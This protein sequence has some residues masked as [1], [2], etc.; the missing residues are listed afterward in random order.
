MQ[1]KTSNPYQGIERG[2]PGTIGWRIHYFEE[3][4]STQDRASQLA[5]QGAAQGTVVIA[6]TQSA[7]HGR[8]GRQWYSPPGLNLYLTIVLRPKSAS[9]AVGGL[10]LMAGVAAAEAIETVAPGIVTLKWPNDVWLRRKKTG[11]NLAKAISDGSQI[12]CVLLGIGLNLNLRSGDIPDDLS[13]IATSVRI[14]TGL[15]CDRIA[16]A[17]AL[18][19]RLDTRYTEMQ[20]HGFA[21]IRPLWERYS[22]LAGRE[23]TVSDH[24]Q[25]LSGVVKGID[26]E[27]ALLLETSTGPARVLS[28]DVS[29]VGAYD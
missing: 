6:E 12:A 14:E 28:G 22:A 9:S 10:N 7:G 3:L 18:F 24:G 21:S 26:D 2:A 25:P 17:A 29:V 13:R 16:V 4:T 19:S 11:G 5:E 23:V 20:K 8:L 1:A 27:G 15:E